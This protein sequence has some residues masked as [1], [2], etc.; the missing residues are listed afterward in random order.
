MREILLLLCVSGLCCCYK[1]AIISNAPTTA[2]TTTPIVLSQSICS[3]SLKSDKVVTQREG[4]VGYRDDLGMYYITVSTGGIDNTLTG[5]VCN[6][7][8]GLKTVDRKVIF[9]GEYFN[10]DHLPRPK[11][12]GET[13]RYLLLKSAKPI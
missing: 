13:I 7:P 11:F 1:T 5:L 4:M 6:M 3:P 12:G 8:D 2:A 10:D 9:D